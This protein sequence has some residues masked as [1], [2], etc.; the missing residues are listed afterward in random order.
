MKLQ[1]LALSIALGAAFGAQA[2]EEPTAP[3]ASA[4]Q[5]KEL[6]EEDSL[7]QSWLKAK[8]PNVMRQYFIRF[9]GGPHKEAMVEDFSK[10]HG[11]YR[12]AGA[13]LLVRFRGYRIDSKATVHDGKTYSGIPGVNSKPS[14]TEVTAKPGTAFVFVALELVATGEVELKNSD[15][16][17]HQ[18]SAPGTRKAPFQ[19]FPVGM[20]AERF[21]FKFNPDKLPHLIMQ[22]GWEVRSKDTERPRV[23]LF[24]SMF[25]LVALKVEKL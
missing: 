18:A 4:P 20:S 10:E 8:D 15:L 14:T 2:A 11:F 24:K 21:D 16:S 1:L 17:F 23:E 7:Y 3:A 9:P 19:L 25:D 6:A 13:P 22:A 5:S 12:I